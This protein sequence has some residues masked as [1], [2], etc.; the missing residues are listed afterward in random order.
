MPHVIYLSG[1]FLLFGNFP[2]LLHY[3][4]TPDSGEQLVKD[5]ERGR[6]GL[7]PQPRGTRRCSA[8]TAT[9]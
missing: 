7:P 2:L 3:L 5:V 6:R 4:K 8:E 9:S 1:V